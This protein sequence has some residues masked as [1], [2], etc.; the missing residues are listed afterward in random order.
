M[1]LAPR[2]NARLLR[3]IEKS[4]PDGSMHEAGETVHEKERRDEGLMLELRRH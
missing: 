4:L 3:S 1:L 2:A